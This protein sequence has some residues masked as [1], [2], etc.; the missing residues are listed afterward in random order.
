MA[1]SGRRINIVTASKA[2]RFLFDGVSLRA[3]ALK[4]TSKRTLHGSLLFM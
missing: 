1:T 4:E 2:L 3:G